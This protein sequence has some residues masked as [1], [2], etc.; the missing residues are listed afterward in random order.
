MKITYTNHPHIQIL[1]SLK[2]P[3]ERGWFVE[4]FNTNYDS[5]FFPGGVKQISQSLS[6]KNV[7]RGFHV[8]PGMA[9][10]MR[11]IQGSIYVATVDVKYESPFYFHQHTAILSAENDAAIFAEDYLA[12][13]FVALEDDTIVEYY[14]TDNYI[15]CKSYT[16]AWDELR[17]TWP[18]NN[19]I[20]SEKDQKGMTIG[21]FLHL[22][23]QWD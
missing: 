23:I 11:V 21:Q 10:M 4:R 22:N 14:H 17:V 9:K 19:P 8:Q 16:I 15:P 2:N 12:R 13:A 18:I 7:L 6:H 20:L 5:Q 3:D 1:E